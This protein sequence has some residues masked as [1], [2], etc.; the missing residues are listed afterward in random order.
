LASNGAAY[1]TIDPVTG[2]FVNATN[3]DAFRET[4]EWLVQLRDERLT[5]HED[6]VGG[7]WDVFRQM[8]NDGQGAM[9]IAANY[10]AGEIFPMLAD[11]WGFVAFPR[12]P[13]SDKHYTWISGE[14]TVIPHFYTPEEVDNFMFAMQRWI[15]PLEEDDP[16]DWIFEAREN[17]RDMRSIDETMKNFTRNPE[18]QVIPAHIM[19]PGL[20]H[21]MD[22]LFAWNVWTGN[23]ASVIIE[24]AQLIWD[25]FLNDVNDMQVGRN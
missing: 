7:E 16:D 18:L 10:V 22:D 14:F 8:F 3:T 5:M 11:D 24:E 17:H 21:S 15:R 19:L 25:A 6:D 12:G 4:L 1:T 20:G 9:R 23:E 13:R 2:R